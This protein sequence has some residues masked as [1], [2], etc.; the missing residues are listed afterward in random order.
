[1]NKNECRGVEGGGE[2]S[3]GYVVQSQSEYIVL[4]K[5]GLAGWTQYKTLGK[6]VRLIFIRLEATFSTFMKVL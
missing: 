5:P 6:A 4:D 2:N 3:G 1:M